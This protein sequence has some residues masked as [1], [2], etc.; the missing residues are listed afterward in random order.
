VAAVTM[1]PDSAGEDASYA[2]VEHSDN[3]P[4][5]LIHSGRHSQNDNMT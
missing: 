4:L 1:L 5:P 2:A 3:L